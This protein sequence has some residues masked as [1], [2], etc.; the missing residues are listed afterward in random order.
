MLNLRKVWYLISYGVSDKMEVF[1]SLFRY[2]TIEI[3]YEILF[4]PKKLIKQ[5]PH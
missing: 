4:I 5:D 3:G 1:D 2:N